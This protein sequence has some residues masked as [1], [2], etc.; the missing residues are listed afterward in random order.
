MRRFVLVVMLAATALAGCENPQR[1]R[2][3]ELERQRDAAQDQTRTLTKQVEK[4]SAELETQRKQIETLQKLG[5]K[6][7]ENLFVVESIEIGRHSGG[8]DLDKQPGHD[9]IQLYLRPKDKDGHLL[10]AAGDVKIQLYDLAQPEEKNLYAEYTFPVKDIGK[11][12]AGGLLSNQYSF[13]CPFPKDAPPAH[14]NI[15]IR[16]E[17]TDY[18]TGNTFSEQKLVKV[19]LPPYKK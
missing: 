10:K 11:Y 3:L 7:M 19:N 13:E 12:W 5:D 16:V 17:F 14:P 1:Q 2:E 6:R 8:V 15:N 9:A 4:L 18:L